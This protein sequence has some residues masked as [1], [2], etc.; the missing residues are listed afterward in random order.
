MSPP[1][2]FRASLNCWAH[3]S[4]CTLIASTLALVIIITRSRTELNSNVCQKYDKKKPCHF[5]HLVPGCVGCAAVDHRLPSSLVMVTVV[6]LI[7]PSWAPPE[8]SKSSISK[9]SSFSGSISFIIGISNI[10]S[11]WEKSTLK[12]CRYQSHILTL[13]FRWSRILPLHFLK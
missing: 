3:V 6:R 8:G 4:L 1:L 5:P 11:T 9:C 13:P 2:T 7:F 12:T 10:T